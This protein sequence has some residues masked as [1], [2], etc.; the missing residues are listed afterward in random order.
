MS[1]MPRVQEV[2]IPILR[3]TLP[4]TVKVGS[5]IEH[6]DDRT[7]PMI[8]V[9]RLGGLARDIRML[10][11]AT[12]ELTAYDST[13]LET[14][15]QLLMDC[16]EILWDARTLQ[17]TVPGKGYIHSYRQTMGPTQ[18]DSPFDDSWRIQSLIQLGIRPNR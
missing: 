12:I 5:W 18:F 11:L 8:N 7:Y 16:M 3:A 17:T 6:I 15:E 9:R 1:N 4:D 10:D 14:T 2:V 13:D